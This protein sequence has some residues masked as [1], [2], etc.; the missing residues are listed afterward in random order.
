[1]VAAE[2]RQKPKKWKISNGKFTDINVYAARTHE[3]HTAVDSVPCKTSNV[4][5]PVDLLKF[6][7]RTITCLLSVINY[8]DVHIGHKISCAHRKMPLLFIKHIERLEPW[9]PSLSPFSML[10]IASLI[11]NVC[12]QSFIVFRPLPLPSLLL[13]PFAAVSI[14]P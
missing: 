12:F 7:T 1:M 2:N 5:C 4:E 11:Q 6:R 3:T 8:Q 14:S 9:L 10:S 13:L